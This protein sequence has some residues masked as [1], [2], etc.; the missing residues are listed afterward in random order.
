MTFSRKSV[1]DKIIPKQTTQSAKTKFKLKSNFKYEN[2]NN[3]PQ[4]SY[5]IGYWM[6]IFVLQ[7][8][9]FPLKKMYDKRGIF[10]YQA[11]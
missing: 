5:T 7:N 3:N 11:S 8:A 10:I 9:H 4:T 2:K 1:I 6:D